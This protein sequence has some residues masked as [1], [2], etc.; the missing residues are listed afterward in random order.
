MSATESLLK[1]LDAYGNDWFPTTIGY[2][3]ARS[4]F[5]TDVTAHYISQ[6]PV[7]RARL[8]IDFEHILNKREMDACFKHRA[9]S[10]LQWQEAMNLAWENTWKHEQNEID[11]KF[12]SVRSKYESRSK[13]G[14][15]VLFQKW[16]GKT[17]SQMAAEVDHKEAYD[18]FY[19]ELSS[20]THVDVRLANRFLRINSDGLSWSQRPKEYD[21]GNVF[22]H[23]ANFLTCF[24]E[25]FSVQFSTWCK[26]DVRNCWEFERTN[27]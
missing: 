25:L 4:M 3:L 22:R 15:K 18:I 6:D 8:Y 26:N 10:N 7:N 2:I 14:K 21:V 1:L 13:S 20:F 19:A 24:L 5:E 23:S 27:R 16:A 11:R 17:L 9:S 12:Q